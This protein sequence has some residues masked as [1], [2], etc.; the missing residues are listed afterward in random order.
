MTT[1][2]VEH[3]AIWTGDLER[4]AGFYARYFGARVGEPYRN[5]AKGFASRFL[6]FGQGARLELM[7][8][9]ASLATA[10]SRGSQRHGL[11]H[12]ALVVGDE[13]AVDALTARLRADGHEVL[14]GPRRTGDGYYESVVLDPD[15]NRV[16]LAAGGREQALVST[17]RAQA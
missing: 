9:T 7:S 2:H 17:G 12:I 10:P 4:L 14:D 8:T 3:V 5:P 15:G 16:E 6:E 1:C 13:S 11:T